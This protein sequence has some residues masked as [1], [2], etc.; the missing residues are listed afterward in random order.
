MSSLALLSEGEA[1]LVSVL[2]WPSSVV[3]VSSCLS[4]GELVVVVSTSTFGGSAGGGVGVAV[5]SGVDVDATAVG[6]RSDG[7]SGVTVIRGV[8]GFITGGGRA[9]GGGVDVSTVGGRAVGGVGVA[10]SSGV[11]VAATAVGGSG[12][13]VESW[14]WCWYVAD[15]SF[16]DVVTST[17]IVVEVGAVGGV[18]MQQRHG[19]TGYSRRGGVAGVD[20]FRVFYCWQRRRREGGL[21]PGCSRFCRCE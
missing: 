18:P 5:R 15:T 6:G 21:V 9:G 13:D 12:V 16:V 1:E 10:V 20:A 4:E 3:S 11:D 14:R 17:A 7:D 2:V 8:D 19:L